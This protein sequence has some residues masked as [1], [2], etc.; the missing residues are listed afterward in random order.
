MENKVAKIGGGITIVVA[1]VTAV[2]LPPPRESSKLVDYQVRCSL[3]QAFHTSYVPIAAKQ[4]GL[5][6]MYF[7]IAEAERPKWVAVIYAERGLGIVDSLHTQKLA[8]D[9]NLYIAGKYATRTSDHTLSGIVWEAIGPSFGVN[10]RWGGRFKRQDGN[11]YE[12]VPE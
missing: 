3:A 11:H 10:T 5:P 8:Q 1:I 12:C 2:L 4:A 6:S 7:V 9:K